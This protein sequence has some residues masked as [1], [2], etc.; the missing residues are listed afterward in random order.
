E[1]VSMSALTVTNGSYQIDDVPQGN[2]PF[3]ASLD[4]YGFDMTTATVI[5]GETVT[6]NFNLLEYVEVMISGT[7]IS[8]LDGEP[9]QGATIN[10]EGF[11]DYQAQTAATGQFIIPGVFSN[12]PYNLSITKPNYNPYYDTI[13]IEEENYD[14]DTMSIFGPITITGFV[15][16]SADPDLG[17]A[18]ALVTLEGYATHTT[19]TDANGQFSIPDVYA[20]E[21]YSI[22]ITHPNYN[23]Y[24]ATV[25]VQGADID[26]GA[27]TLISPINITGHV[28]SNLDL[29]TG[30]VNADIDLTGYAYYTTNSDSLGNFTIDSV[31]ANEDYEISIDYPNHNIYTQNIDVQQDYIDLGTI[32][33]IGPV[34]VYGHVYGSDDLVNGLAD[35]DIDLVGH[36]NHSTITDSTGYYEF[37]E[38]FANQEYTVNI[39]ADG[40]ADYT[41]Q[42]E[43]GIANLEVDDIIIT[44]DF[45]PTS[46]VNAV[47]LS[48]LSTQVSWDTPGSESTYEFRYD[49]GNQ[50]GEIG[51]N[52]ARAVIGAVHEY[53]AVIDQ[54][55]WYL[56]STHTHPR[57]KI[58][59]FGITSTGMPNSNNI[60]YESG[61]IT[62][63]NNQWRTY[64]L[65]TPVSAPNGFFVGIST[66]NNWTDLG[67][68]D[69]NGEPWVFQPG[70]QF[71]AVDFETNN[72]SDISGYPDAGNLMLRAYGLNI[73]PLRNRELEGYKLFRMEHDNVS[74]PDEWEVIAE[75][76]QDTTYTDSTWWY[77]DEGTWYY[78]VICQHTNGVESIATFSN[79]LDKNDPPTFEADFY[80]T[81]SN[82]N[83]LQYCATN[84]TS[85]YHTYNSNSN[86]QGL[87]DYTVNPG[88]YDLHISKNGYDD[89][90][91][92]DVLITDDFEMDIMLDSTDES[93]DEIISQ[94]SLI[95]VYPNPFNPETTL[96][97]NLQK[98]VHTTI[99]VYNLKGQKIESI[100][101]KQL[102]AGSHSVT[103]DAA[104]Q[105]SGIYLIKFQADNVTQLSK[106]VLLK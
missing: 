6:V 57:V 90:D 8:E 29:E 77:L 32:T 5:A 62:N 44:E 70:T 40:Y 36:G 19:N 100:V 91:L 104:Q 76:L 83:P 106:A 103:W 28:V 37:T 49:D 56:T 54:V 50:D 92:E 99:E 55:K 102:P 38:V 9:V 82:G 16:T 4:G 41:M 84:L 66:P 101:D 81:A 24:M 7:V 87:A 2:H 59:I 85:F 42:V 63:V 1:D 10:L 20:N 22:E 72:W 27:L 78:A 48:E 58:K 26:L 79:A 23:S 43:V 97:F 96:S 45:S 88:V 25:D 51:L 33:L 12:N 13:I 80:I 14:C 93:D 73:G 35:A 69:G 89:Y 65:P 95:G 11:A 74:D 86:S 60:L 71:S 68:D 105:P 39:D 94:T 3:F 67:M 61:L 52:A 30:L 75:N 31:Y 98:A 18:G 17:L 46:N 47:I 53:N 34:T 64:N 21:N 15:Y